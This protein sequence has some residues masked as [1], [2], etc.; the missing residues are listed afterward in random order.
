MDRA[1]ITVARLLNRPEL[2][3][4]VRKNLEMMFYYVH[5]DGE[6]VT[7]ASRR[8][9]RN[10]RTTMGRYYYAY[11]TL[12]LLDGNGHFAAMCQQI[13]RGA[14]PSHAGDLADY[15]AE[16][17]LLRPLPTAISLPPI[18]PNCSPIRA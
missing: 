18:T 10:Q 5:S 7:E 9:D 12:A 15:L 17:E 14:R 3:E 16:P 4:P 8:Q 13:E 11:R 1:L 6:V 2:Y